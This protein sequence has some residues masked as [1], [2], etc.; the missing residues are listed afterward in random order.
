MQGPG[1]YGQPYNGQHYGNGNSYPSAHNQMNHY[2]HQSSY[3]H[4]S[5]HAP[6][7]SQHGYGASPNQVQY[8]HH[9]QQQQQQHHQQ[10]YPPQLDEFAAPPEV[11]SDVNAFSRFFSFHLS[12]LTFNSKPVITNLTLFAHQH[13][14]RMSGVVAQC[15]DD[16]LRLCP[17]E[18]RLPALYLLDSIS[19]NIGQPYTTLFARFIER[20]FLETYQVVDQNTKIKMEELL[21]TWRTGG[22]DKGELFRLPDEGRTG[23]RVQRGIEHT[24]FGSAGRGGGIGGGGRAMRENESYMAGVQQLP[25]VASQSERSAVLA[26]VRRL[27]SLRHDQAKVHPEDA[28]NASQ[29]VALQK[30]EKLVLETQLTSDQ[31]F[32]IREQL[33]ALAPPEPDTSVLAPSFPLND[34]TGVPAS[35]LVAQNDISHLSSVPGG[36]GSPP[37]DPSAAAGIDLNLLATLQGLAGSG[38]LAQLL[39]AVT[40]INGAGGGTTPLHVPT[41]ADDYAGA[42][43]PADSVLTDPLTKDYEDAVVALDIQLSNSSI[44]RARPEASA[45]VYEKLP[46]QCKQCGL[47]YFDS[48]VGKKHMDAHLDWHFTHK[49]RIREGAGRPQGRSWLSLEDDWLTSDTIDLSYANADASTSTRKADPGVLDRAELLKRKVIAPTDPSKLNTPCPVCKERFKSEW[50]ED[51]EEW[52]FYNCVEVEG[53]L[54]HAT[55]HAEAGASRLA[56]KLRLDESNRPSRESTPKLSTSAN[57]NG[58]SGDGKK[59]KNEWDDLDLGDDVKRP[60]AEPR[61]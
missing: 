39:G 35:S 51:D 53:V 14:L 36:A 40:P 4:Q 55:C 50:S 1:A 26:D 59:R 3:R 47:R 19:K 18:N 33:A 9:P 46:L 42:T 57:E 12:Q 20:R 43:S 21:G 45:F 6:P 44:I 25:S 7:P 28:V 31:V 38:G 13:L 29:I 34:V 10:Q 30:L 5:Q 32:Q 2:D 8:G 58:A 48:V 52:V 16:H 23:G 49:R 15:L 54:F 17:P 41:V 61:E 11:G 60:K 24:L 22:P 56:A 27:L 37:V